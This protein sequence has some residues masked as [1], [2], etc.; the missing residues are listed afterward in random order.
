MAI[1][2]LRPMTAD[3]YHR[4]FQEYESDPDLCLDKST[5][6]PYVYDAEKVDRYIQ[7]QINLHRIPFAIEHE[8][9]MVGEILL[10]NITPEQCATLS[11]SMKQAKYKDRGF[12]TASEKLAIDYV[13][14]RLDIPTLYADTICTNIR[15]QHVLEKVGFRLIGEDKNFKYYRIDRPPVPTP[16]L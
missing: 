6:T 15:S 10:K 12:G 7:K 16:H 11:L 9:E 3:M 14:Y 1:I 4:Y 5:Y 13:F 8:G 2:H